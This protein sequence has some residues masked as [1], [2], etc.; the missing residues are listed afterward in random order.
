MLLNTL[1]PDELL[2]AWIHPS[3]AAALG[4]KDGD[5]I[6]VRPAAPKVLEQLKAV[7]VQNVPTARFKVRVTNM[8]RPDIIAIYHYWL[9]PKGR[10]RVKAAKLADI[11]AG[12]SDD[13]YFGAMMAGKL[14]TPGAMGNTVVEV[15]RV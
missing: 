3:T 5:W 7:G 13:N 1:T 10:L 8:V 9:V 11:R 14:G 6:E 2:T 15:A 4:V 12:D